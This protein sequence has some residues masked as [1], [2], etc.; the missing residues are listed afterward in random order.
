MGK[1]DGSIPP[2]SSSIP[3]S[4]ARGGVR[5][6]RG[7]SSSGLTPGKGLPLSKGH[8]PSA[9]P[10]LG[11]VPPIPWATGWRP[12]ARSEPRGGDRSKAPLPPVTSPSRGPANWGAGVNLV[13]CWGLGGQVNSVHCLGAVGRGRPSGLLPHPSVPSLPK[14]CFSP[15]PPGTDL[16]RGRAGDGRQGEMEARR[17]RPENHHPVP[18]CPRLRLKERSRARGGGPPRR[19]GGPR[20]SPRGTLGLVSPPLHCIPG[21][22]REGRGGTRSRV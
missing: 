15:A 6:G 22:R 12:G 11:L 4:G 3:P 21:S 14:P 13:H 8:H 9:V 16:G 19:R 7:P 10:G 20:P 17:L 5:G 2:P 1:P 18:H